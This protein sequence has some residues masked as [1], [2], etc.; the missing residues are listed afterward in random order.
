MKRITS[1]RHTKPKRN[2]KVLT[3]GPP[4]WNW[5]RPQPSRR[6][7]QMGRASVSVPSEPDRRFNVV[8]FR[9]LVQAFHMEESEV[10]KRIFPSPRVF[11]QFQAVK[12]ILLAGDANR[13]VAELTFVRINDL[14]APPDKID[15]LL[16]LEPVVAL[17]ILGNGVMIG[18]QSSDDYQ[19]W[20]GWFWFEVG[21]AL[22][23]I[24]EC[25]LRNFVGGCRN[26][27]CGVER[28]WNWC[29]I[30]FIG[31]ALTDILLEL[32]RVD[33]GAMF[34][35]TLLRFVRLVRLTRIVKVFRLHW[36]KELR[37]MLKGLV[38]SMQTL[39]MAFVLLFVV[40]YVLAGLATYTL[41]RDDVLEA[42][43]YELH[44]LFENLP[45]SM[46]TAFRCFTGQ[47]ETI[48]GAP[49]AAVLGKEIGLPFVIPYI[50]SYML[51]SMG[52]FNVILAVYVDITM[53]AAKENEATTAE[54]HA[55]ESVRIARTTREL[56]KRFAAANKIF[57]DREAEGLEASSRPS[58]RSRFDL[59]LS[60]QSAHFTD[61]AMQDEIE[62]TKELF[63][64]VVQ[65]PSVQ[66][67]MDDLD[68]PADRANLFEVIDADQSGTLHVSELVQGLLKVRGDLKKSDA[69][70]GLLAT[71]SLQQMVSDMREEMRSFLQD[72]IQKLPDSPRNTIWERN[73]VEGHAL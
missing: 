2:S 59:D 53:R 31:T 17:T 68:L 64:L 12:E 66:G 39:L 10:A 23:L 4:D 19:N 50:C 65:D 20:P 27:F 57:R 18:F 56:L 63:L 73:G 32:L 60:P 58:V 40:L 67:L 54:Q 1:D 34:F 48:D 43:D 8:P 69:V 6:M 9:A 25:C 30:G 46:F 49:L 55:R 51:V 14:A 38:G 28:I 24:L 26:Y 29:D 44:A 5:P 15:V 16:Y 71:Q 33:S 70:A 21:F 11:A 7:S 47:C 41:G 36:M 22:V 42:K 61:Q 37:L 35:T 52:I 62:I 72:V 45:V 3:S 13:L